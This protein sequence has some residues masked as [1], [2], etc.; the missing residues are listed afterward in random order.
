[1]E[2]ILSDTKSPIGGNGSFFGQSSLFLGLTLFVI[3]ASGLGIRLYDLTDPPLDFHS[4]RQLRSAIIA[5]GLYYSNLD[6][7][8]DWQR[9]RAQGQLESHNLIEPPV[10]EATAAIV[11]RM[12]G[13]D[14][15]WIA[16]ILASIFWLIGGVALYFL[17]RDMTSP[18]G[19]VIAAAFYMFVPFGIIASRSFQPDPLMVMFI[20]LG[21]WSIFRWYQRPSWN[22]AIFAG[23]LSG[24]ALFVKAVAL[25]FV[26]VPFAGLLIVGRGFK[27]SLKDPRVWMIGVLTVLPMLAY[28]FYGVYI[29]GSLE[30]QFEGRF[31]PEMWTDP[32]F[33][34]RWIGIASSFVGYG[35]I[36]GSFVGVLLFVSA[37]RR[38]YGI[39]LWLG[40]VLYGMT[41]PYH[42][43]THSYY[44]LPLIPV[45]ALSLA[46]LA[47]VAMRPLNQLKP[48][49]LVRV[50]FLG[51]LFAGILGKAWDART[52]LAS[53]DFR[54]E[55]AYW[56]EIAELL[57]NESSIVALTHDYG[58]RLAYYGWIT[59][60][61]WLPQG[62]IEK[63]RELRGGSPIDVQEW[64]AEITDNR[65]F[66][67]VTLINQLNKQPE[68]EELLY[69]NYAIYAEGDGFVIFDLHRPLQ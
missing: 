58:N 39:G 14:D 67:L 43:I 15:L 61:V 51:I 54:H 62:H 20:L 33:Y 9:E 21:L 1:L 48:L 55:P 26:L 65:D 8:P 59:P 23:V 44:H 31:F 56:E 69:T 18:D 50:A 19:G 46:P 29:L 11:Y 10:F 64:F 52:D 2:F 49:S 28:H 25:F 68:L 40:Y 30:S 42:F 47:A 32:T 4:T 24:A 3:F 13:S 41:F 60:K 37:A 53:Q 35:S 7:A 66:F 22:T 57:G 34:A 36:L 5:R 27:K 63:Y 16:R 17:A 6:T 38:A 45:V 12:V